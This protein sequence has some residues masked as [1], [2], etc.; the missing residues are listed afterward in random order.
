MSP[1]KITVVGQIC[2]HHSNLDPFAAVNG[3]SL[4]SNIGDATLKLAI[5]DPWTF[6]SSF[7]SD[8]LRATQNLRLL[9]ESVTFPSFAQSFGIRKTLDME[10]L[11]ND[12]IVLRI[13]FFRQKVFSL[14]L[15]SRTI[16]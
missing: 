11:Y 15:H 2:N 5:T 8:F 12:L 10:Q 3:W 1:A 13:P 7:H 4:P 14:L 6:S 9:T 16:F